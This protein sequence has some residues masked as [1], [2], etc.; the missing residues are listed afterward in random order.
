MVST[1]LQAYAKRNA[2]PVAVK[3]SLALVRCLSAQITETVVVQATT[4]IKLGTMQQ[5]EAGEATERREVQEGL[6]APDPRNQIT[7]AE[8]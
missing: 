2:K 6:G 5:V 3:A 7:G 8:G 4:T 1:R